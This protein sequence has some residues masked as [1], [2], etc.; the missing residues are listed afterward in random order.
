M[1]Q[2]LLMFLECCVTSP[3]DH[4]TGAQNMTDIHQ[5]VAQ[6]EAAVEYIDQQHG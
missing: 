5:Q 4:T 1:E 2:T 3:L 6:F